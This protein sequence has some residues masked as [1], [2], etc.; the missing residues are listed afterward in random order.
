MKENFMNIEEYG[1]YILYTFIYI[2]CMIILKQ[3]LNLKA[4]GHY[5]A[6]TELA[7]GNL[8]VGL[9]RTGAQL[10]LAIAMMGVLA[11]TTQGTL[12]DDLISSLTYGLIAVAFIVSSL[13]LTD[14]FIL[15][16][17]NNIEA[18]KERNVSVGIVEFGMLTATGIIAY[19]SIVGEGG[20]FIS[21]IVYFLAGQL[22]LIM[23]VLVYE[24]LV[25]RNINIV[26]TISNKNTSL[27]IYIGGKLIAY[28][29]ILKSAISGNQTE[30]PI[31]DKIIEFIV[32]AVTGMILLY[33]FE[34]IIDL[35]IVTSSNMLTI[36]K[37]DQVVPALQI[38]VGKLGIALILSNAIL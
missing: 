24:K 10:G 14:K 6:D 22:T 16:G 20:G 13:V 7:S 31:N 30:I 3:I 29:L 12:I 38:T 11:G 28:A 21:S 34:F 15:P 1:I 19:S 18:L 26:E 37:Q 17:V 36:I 32:I 8:A 33:V 4:T 27:G 2:I 9:R 23:L 5:D 25:M 35:F